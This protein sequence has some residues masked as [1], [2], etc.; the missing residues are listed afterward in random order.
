MDCNELKAPFN[1]SSLRT[2]LKQKRLPLSHNAKTHCHNTKLDFQKHNFSLS[3]DCRLSNAHSRTIVVQWC[4]MVCM[5]CTMVYNVLQSPFNQSS[6]EISLKQ[7]QQSLSH[8]GKN[9]CTNPKI[10][11]QKPSSP[12]LLYRRTSAV[13][14]VQFL[15]NSEQFLESPELPKQPQKSPE[16]NSASFVQQRFWQLEQKSCLKNC[17]TAFPLQRMFLNRGLAIS[18][19]MGSMNLH[20]CVNRAQ[21]PQSP[22]PK[23]QQQKQPKTKTADI[24]TQ[25]QKPLTQHKNCNHTKKKLLISDGPKEKRLRINGAGWGSQD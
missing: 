17:L 1:S 9:H 19:S 21:L 13:W 25:W 22:V 5:R 11:F 20:N 16:T 4:T 7:K 24:A 15:H 3:I 23:K 14:F 18:C 12:L 2:S 10:D 8:N 6:F